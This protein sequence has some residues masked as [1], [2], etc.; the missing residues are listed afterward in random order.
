MHNPLFA[1][2]RETNK[3]KT[4]DTETA[5]LDEHELKVNTAINQD[6]EAFQN[7]DNARE[8]AD[9]QNAAID[10]RVNSSQDERGEEKHICYF[11]NAGHIDVE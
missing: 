5:L 9:R 11:R 1:P 3:K 6:D 4:S 7:A 2:D 10:R 8:E